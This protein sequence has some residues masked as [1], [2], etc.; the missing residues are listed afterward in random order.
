[1][2]VHACPTTAT[3]VTAAM[4]LTARTRQMEAESCLCDMAD[5]PS[6]GPDGLDHP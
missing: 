6:L 2:Q 5:G 4:A 3:A 1:M